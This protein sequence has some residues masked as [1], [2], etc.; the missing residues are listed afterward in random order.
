[1]KIWGKCMACG[2]TQELELKE[3]YMICERCKAISELEEPIAYGKRMSFYKLDE[4]GVPYER[5]N[6]I[7]Y[8]NGEVKSDKLKNMLFNLFYE[9]ELYEDIISALRSYNS[10][11]EITSEEYDIIQT[12][13]DKWLEEYLNK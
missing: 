12:N 11:G 3:S 4:L 6:G 9:Y 7:A 8:Y 13:Y 1:M 5:V 10:D 2:H